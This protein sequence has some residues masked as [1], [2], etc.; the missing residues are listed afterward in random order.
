MS[1]ITFGDPFHTWTWW[2]WRWLRD[3][4][5]SRLARLP[6][7]LRALVAEPK[8]LKRAVLMTMAKPS[9]DA[10][11][12]QHAISSPDETMR[13]FQHTIIPHLDAA[14]NF[15]RFLSRDAN[16]AEDIVQEAY[17]RAYRGFGGFRDGDARAWTFTIVRNCYHAW[18]QEGRRKARYEQPMGDDRDFDEGSPSPDPASE[19]DTPEAAFIRKTETLRVREVINKL[20]DTMREVLVLR[21][22]EDLSYKEIA[23]IID[24]PIGTVMSRLARARRDFGEVWRSLEGNEAAR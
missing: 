6:T 7:R 13:R 11:S 3:T 24:A 22:L 20:P 17:L 12:L 21:E 1:S 9:A 5:T 4:A 19:E 2:T 8:T 16:A 10:A 15:A 14:Y 18:L 23:E